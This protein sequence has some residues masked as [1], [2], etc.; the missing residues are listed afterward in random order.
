MIQQKTI[1]HA[2][3]LRAGRIIA[4]LNNIYRIPEGSRETVFRATLQ[5]TRNL[6]VMRA[7]AR[8]LHVLPDVVREK[9]EFIEAVLEHRTDPEIKRSVKCN[10]G[11][12]SCCPGMTCYPERDVR[13]MKVK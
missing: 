6:D 3:D 2:P 13:M 4:L 12:I 9:K 11:Y 8:N 5:Y 1:Q 10:F 7:L